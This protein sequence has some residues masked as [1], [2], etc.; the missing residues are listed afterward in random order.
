ME[1]ISSPKTP[2]MSVSVDGNGTDIIDGALVMAG[3]TAGTNTSAVI[4]ATGASADAVGVMQ[5][6]H[7]A[8]V[9]TDTTP[10]DGLI[11]IRRDVSP[12]V[13]GCTVAIEYD[14]SDTAIQDGGGSSTTITGTN[15]E[16]DIDG[17]WIYM[18]SGTGIGQLFYIKSSTTSTATI[19]SAAGTTPAS[20]DTFIKILPIFH[21]KFKLNSTSDKIG[22]DLA[23][24][25]S[26]LVWVLLK[27]QIR[28]TD[29]AGWIDLD[30]T[31]HH[32][33]S[34]LNSKFVHFQG[35]YAP[36]NTIYSPGV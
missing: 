17:G 28:Y 26:P 15:L 3:A 21:A 36:R 9:D 33:L 34:G 22:T 5:G 24:P 27:N 7:D 20:S 16:D 25:G 32:N 4:L 31:V 8:S 35:L 23:V 13:P 12:F 18:V 10:D 6:L 2:L 11:D 30:P 19:K 14:Q 29:T 1:I